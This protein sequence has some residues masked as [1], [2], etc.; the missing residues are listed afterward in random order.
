MN[1][2]G[3]QDIGVVKNPL[4][5]PDPPLCFFMTLWQSTISIVDGNSNPRQESLHRVPREHIP[6]T[7]CWLDIVLR[8]HAHVHT[9]RWQ[10]KSATAYC[11]NSGS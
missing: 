11:F 8:A 3:F 6:R 2:C 5:I 1:G 7:V 4:L 10:L 9:D